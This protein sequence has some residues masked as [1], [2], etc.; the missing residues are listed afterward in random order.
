MVSLTGGEKDTREP[1]LLKAKPNN[2]QTN[3]NSN[4][5]ELVFD[6]YLQLKNAEEQL[7]ISPNNGLKIKTKMKD[8]HAK[9]CE[10]LFF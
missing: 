3:F 8:M 6:E 4:T 5:I 10:H 2:F 1:I 7:I 9:L